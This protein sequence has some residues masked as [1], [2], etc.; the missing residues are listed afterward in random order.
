MGR[1]V[2]A[3]GI[4]E[5]FDAWTARW[6]QE[7][8]AAAMDESFSS[9]VE[10]L[11]WAN[12]ELWHEEDK[13]RAI[14]AGDS[15]VATAKRAIDRINQ[16]RNDQIEQCDSLLL[17]QLAAKHLPNPHAELHSETPGMMLD[18]LSIMSLKR[19]HTLEELRR[20]NAPTGHAV[21]NHERLSVLDRQ[22]SD[23]AGCFDQLWQQVLRGKRRFQLY[24]QLKM[25]N[26]PELNPVLYNGSRT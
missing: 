1:M 22:R 10:A 12:F 14:Q 16:A 17:G 9:A 25:Y 19:Y 24:R 2:T 4:L 15:A 13:A 18:R 6:H 21:R 3:G 11:H 5:Q 7:P 20:P 26:D 8:L 23:L